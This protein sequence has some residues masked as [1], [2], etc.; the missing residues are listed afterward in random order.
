MTAVHTSAE[1]P[2]SPRTQRS[3]NGVVIAGAGVGGSFLALLLG[4]SGLR[5]TVVEPAAHIAAHGADFL[6]PRGIRLLSDQGLL[7]ELM[8]RG[9][10]RRDTISYYHDGEVLRDF[11]YQE[12][13]DLGYFLILPYRELVTAIVESARRLPNVEFA[14]GTS[15][16]GAESHPADKTGTADEEHTGISAVLLSDGR[17]LTAD[18]VVDAGGP[19][20]PVRSFVDPRQQIHEYDH[21]VR[22]ATLAVTPSIA[23]RNR[24][25]FESDGWFAYFYPVSTEQARLFVGV[26]RHEAAA[27]FG[28]HRGK[29]VER[30][31]GF[32]TG[33][34]D[35][36]GQVETARFVPAPVMALRST[37]YHRGNVARLGSTLFSCHPMTGQGMSY[38]MEDASLLADLIIRSAEGG[39]PLAKLLSHDYEL[40]RTVHDRLVDYG[41]DLAVSYPDPARYQQVFQPVLHGGDR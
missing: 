7:P 22:M 19:P 14:F 33:S 3:H 11:S 25:Y 1:Q 28:E 9:A 38:T 39:P 36:L 35:A 32:A 6:K 34:A 17:R 16:D 2:L 24:L 40:R 21:D 23:E 30:L 12:H 20:S 31:R 37:P 18:A 29:L 27:V 8:S 4:R 41:D 10:L 5:V 15:I 26:P 13:T